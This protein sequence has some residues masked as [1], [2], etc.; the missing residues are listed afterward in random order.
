MFK[1]KRKIIIILMT[2]IIIS[3]SL[4]LYNSYLDSQNDNIDKEIKLSEINKE[5]EL[6]NLLY[7]RKSI[8]NYKNKAIIFE[9]ISEI[10][11][12]SEG[13]NVDGISGPTRTSPSAGATNPLEIYI[14]I[15]NVNNITNGLYKYVPTEHKLQ[16]LIK[17][18]LSQ[19]LAAAALNQAPIA[20][21]PA[22]IIITAN[23]D[24]TTKRYGERGK[25][26]VHMEAGMAAQNV[27]LTAESKDLSGVIIGAF[28]N[29]KIKKV[30]GNIKQT[31]LLI[32]PLGYN[33]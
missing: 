3:S 17:N 11:W 19:A 31:P 18:N 9:D 26:Y 16:K 29:D 1:N 20:D 6:I 24:E 33:K 23:Y 5:S 12:A 32:I 30:M 8:R 27:I 14:L 15:S 10:I 22:S 4:L 21:A 25:K 7:N 2:V 13:I 28:E